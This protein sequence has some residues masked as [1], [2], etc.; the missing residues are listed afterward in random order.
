MKTQE[1]KVSS[2]LPAGQYTILKQFALF[3]TGVKLEK[4]VL[5][6]ADFLFTN[7]KCVVTMSARYI[8]AFYFIRNLPQGLKL[9]IP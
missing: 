9:K 3:L 5:R 4:F 6:G 1:E 7:E 8:H 2:Q